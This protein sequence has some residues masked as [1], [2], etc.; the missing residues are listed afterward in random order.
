[1]AH[2]PD[3]FGLLR[4]R[5]QLTNLRIARL[6]LLHKAD[7]VPA[8]DER[9]VLDEMYVTDQEFQRHLSALN[10]GTREQISD[11]DALASL[12]AIDG[13]AAVLQRR[14]DD[15][16][17]AI[18]EGG[19]RD[20]FEALCG[21]CGLLAVDREL[22]LLVLA[23][24]VDR[25]Y[26]RVFAYLHDDFTRGL[27]SVGLVMDILAPLEQGDR[28]A[29]LARLEA[30]A[31]LMERG[32]LRL[33]E[34][35]ADDRR[36]LTQRHL[37][38]ADAAAGL[39][40]GVPRLDEGAVTRARLLP[41]PD[42]PSALSL[43]P[44]ADERM[45]A[46]AARI[47]AAKR[48]VTVFVQGK[49]AAATEAG[50]D[51]LCH[52]LGKPVLHL[53]L[54][55]LQAAGGD[56]LAV[57]RRLVQDAFLLS[58]AVRVVGFPDASTQEPAAMHAVEVLWRAVQRHEG[59]I[60]VP[61][62]GAP[63]A[64]WLLGGRHA[65]TWR[66]E[67]PDFS[68]RAA[69][70]DALVRGAGVP[71]AV[72]PQDVEALS[73]RYRMNRQQLQQTVAYARDLAWARATEGAAGELQLPDLVE[74]A[75]AQFS[76]S[77]GALAAR[78]E[79]RFSFDELVLPAP[80]KQHLSELLAFVEQRGRVYESWG[81]RRSFTRGTGAKA[82]FFGASGTGKTMAA[83]V[84]ARRLGFDL[85]KVDLSSV[86]SKWVGE[87]EK[88]LGAIFDRAEE[89][90]AV[91]LFDEAD[92][93]FGSRT[94]VTSSVDRYANLETNYLLQR[95]EEYDGVALLS[96]NLKQN[97]DDAFTRRFHFVI[98]FPY[99]DTDAREEIWQRS[100]PAQAP[101]ADDVDFRFLAERFKFTGGNIKN[102]VLRAAFLGATDGEEISMR[103]LLRGVTR[104]YQNLE[105]DLG[106]RDFGPWWSEVQDL[107]EQRRGTRRKE[108][109]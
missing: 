80:Q 14:L 51:L 17:R 23:P 46:V 37:L 7:R 94:Q 30:G 21:R 47:A 41:A 82:L 91:L 59:L 1:M 55:L 64:S 43:P 104:E 49:E 69:S 103:H 8:Q 10:G 106:P 90:Q 81:F 32:L 5:L 74:G 4:R 50:C 107:I 26:R 105:R 60:V 63:P 97:I 15:E 109:R 95:I 9:D 11:P 70:L 65:I 56:A 3:G 40:L 34:A 22:L 72:T 35:R 54:A 19:L 13:A 93:L 89:A 53:D 88:N 48:G 45:G 66:I 83:E 27:P 73:N 100:L 67:P 39:L 79:P 36:P 18:R 28:L 77:V 68:E 57:V 75:Q 99:P 98:E 6:Y 58:A 29:V 62:R 92:S 101:L 31:P 61:V 71:S 25:R 86:V 12:D 102:S 76:Q 108:R 38:T 85:F 52:L 87:T 44:D 16:E 78:I 20:P 2:A 24:E 84:I 33:L 42:R 96:S